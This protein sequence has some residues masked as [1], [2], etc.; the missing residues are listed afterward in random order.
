MGPQ[1]IVEP[2]F[3]SKKKACAKYQRKGEIPTWETW[4]YEVGLEME[5]FQE[6]TFS[7]RYWFLYAKE[8]K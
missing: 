7:S 6:C 2:A 8:R 1:F 4:K 3:H 5:L